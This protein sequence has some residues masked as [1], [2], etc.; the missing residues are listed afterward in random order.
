MGGDSGR[1]VGDA[2]PARRGAFVAVQRIAV[3]AALARLREAIPARGVPAQRGA[4]V[5]RVEVAVVA[6]LLARQD[7]PVAARGDSA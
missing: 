1:D 2:G 3:V 7:K 6:L 4:R 5:G